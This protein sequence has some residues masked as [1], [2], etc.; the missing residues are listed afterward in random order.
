MPND[1]MTATETARATDAASTTSASNTPATADLTRERI[2]CLDCPSD[3]EPEV[4]RVWADVR[5]RILRRQAVELQARSDGRRRSRH[6]CGTEALLRRALE[7]LR[8]A[9]AAQRRA[10]VRAVFDGWTEAEIGMLLR[11][12]P[13]A[14]RADLAVA[15]ARAPGARR[16]W[17]GGMT[18]QAHLATFR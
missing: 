6:V 2:V 5:P 7:A 15:R 12:S 1:A 8:G 13:D 4:R 11:R 10:F 3:G 17:R 9:P 18:R 16:T 14:V